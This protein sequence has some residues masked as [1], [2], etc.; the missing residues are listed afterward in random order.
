MNEY[1]VNYMDNELK[2]IVSRLEFASSVES[3]IKKYINTN[4]DLIKI[5]KISD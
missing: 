2:R 4:L 1:L 3:L 5:E